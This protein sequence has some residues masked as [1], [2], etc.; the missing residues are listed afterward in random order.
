[1]SEH[2]IATTAGLQSAANMRTHHHIGHSILVVLRATVLAC[3]IFAQGA[4]GQAVN[5][6][7][8]AS[9][10]SFDERTTSFVLGNVEFLLLH[11]L[12]HFLIN[13]KEIPIIGPEENAADYLATIALLR[14]EPFDTENQD[15][16]LDFLLAAADAF[17]MSW[18]IGSALGAEIPYWGSHALGIQR[19]YQIACLI[20]GS[21]PVAFAR[22]VELSG[23][24]ESRARNCVTEFNKA[25]RA[26]QWLLDTFGRRPD[27][28]PSTSVQIVYEQ[29]RSRITR[30]LLGEIQSS[31]LLEETLQRLTNLFTFEE[32]LLVAMRHCDMPEAAWLPAQRELVICYELLDTIYLLSLQQEPDRLTP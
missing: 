16:T 19:Y 10:D 9:S 3:L 21:D 18:A 20:Y 31:N 30:R 29:P 2:S 6:P 5:V 1:M 26:V 7:D 12:A 11:E 17:S 15:Q 22:I 4:S 28:P 8:R 32:P 27:D 14:T 24:P 25:D 13:E 23:L